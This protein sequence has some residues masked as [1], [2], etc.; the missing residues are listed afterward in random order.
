MYYG[1]NWAAA[2]VEVTR[3]YKDTVIRRHDV[4][5][6]QAHTYMHTQWHWIKTGVT[7]GGHRG[8]LQVMVRWSSYANLCVC[9]SDCSLVYPSHYICAV[10]AFQSPDKKKV[11]T[12]QRTFDSE[13]KEYT[14]PFIFTPFPFIF[15]LSPSETNQ[16]YLHFV[17]KMLF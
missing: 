7:E 1:T 10:F 8:H 6:H 12:I 16:K 4:M 13:G 15:L 5:G 17:V 11:L 3:P 2:A 9:V 14:F